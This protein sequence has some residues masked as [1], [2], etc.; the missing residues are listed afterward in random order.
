VDDAATAL[1]A[2]QSAAVVPSPAWCFT[3]LGSGCAVSAPSEPRIFQAQNTSDARHKVAAQARLYSDAKRLW[4]MRLSVIFQLAAASSIAALLA[5][6]APRNVFGV[7]G[8]VLLLVLSVVGGDVEKRKRQ[9]AAAVQESFDVE[10]FQLPW[11]EIELKRPSPTLISQAA[12][13]YDGGRDADWYSDTK[14]T[15]RPFDVL[16]CQSSNLGWGASTHLAWAWALTAM[17][18]VGLALLLIAA[19]LDGLSFSDA[20]V[21]IGVPTLAPLKEILEQ[22]KAHLETSR[23]K[24]DAQAKI[25]AAWSD[26]MNG[27]AVPDEALLRLVQNKMLALRQ[28]PHY[29]PDWFDNRLRD[30]NEAA[31]HTTAED[32]LAQAARAGHG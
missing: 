9:Q 10:V 29:V 3:A 30:R 11:N 31:M 4:S 25:S 23:D 14:D 21:A 20:A 18:T 8:G 15:H 27:K 16:I 2:E 1:A 5:A 12:A 26:G 19:K 7:G 28:R 6:T 17:L 32:M 24:E 13:R 22:I